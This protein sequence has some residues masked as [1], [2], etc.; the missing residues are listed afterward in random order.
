MSVSIYLI[1]DIHTVFS[2]SIYCY[3]QDV[4]KKMKDRDVSSLIVVD[5][6]GIS[7][8]WLPN[9]IWLQRYA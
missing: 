7:Q 3:F 8:A 1:V 5:A 2:G 9:E 6:G 4:A